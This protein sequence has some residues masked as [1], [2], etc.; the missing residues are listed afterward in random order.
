ME[1]EAL[2][3]RTPTEVEASCTH[4]KTAARDDEPRSGSRGASFPV[5][6]PL[7]EAPGTPERGSEV[8]LRSHVRQVVRLHV[9]I[10]VVEEGRQVIKHLVV[11]AR[12]LLKILR[13]HR[14][15]VL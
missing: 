6:Q 9:G 12:D 7:G 10:P 8:Q 4:S 3:Y 1:H 5:S 2:G 11:V 14:C 15:G 13:G